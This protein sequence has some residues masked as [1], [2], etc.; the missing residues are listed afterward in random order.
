MRIFKHP[1]AKIPL[2]NGRDV[3]YIMSRKLVLPVNKENVI[4]YGILDEKYADQI[5]DQI[6]LQIPEGK[7]YLTKQELFMLDLLSNYQWDRPINLLSMGGDINI[8]IKDYLMY[9][10]FS[11]KFVPIKNATKSTDIGFADPEDLYHKMKE[12]FKW[13]ALK[14]TDY[15]VDYQNFYTFCGVL[16]QRNLFVNAA[17]EMLKIGD[18]E[19]AVELLDMCQE[20]VPEENFPLDIT[21]LGFSNEYM[22]IDMIDT[23]YNAGAPEKA[24]ALAE[25]F[26]DELLYSSEF[27]LQF[28][29]YARREFEACYNCLSYVA[30][31]TD[32]Y[33]DTEFAKSVRDRFNALLGEE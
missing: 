17:K 12:V 32:I 22:V 24:L 10:G 27:F 1:D 18:A 9:E 33:G 26:V 25:R 2:S 31:L 28:Y 30:D 5:P 4:R 3:D 7:D 16:S 21:Y 15:F 29:D 11:Y 6:V 8:G 19:R 23:Y 20:C 13:D 14:R